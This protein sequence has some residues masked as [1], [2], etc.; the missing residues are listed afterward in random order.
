VPLR[1]TICCIAPDTIPDFNP[2]KI[3][4]GSFYPKEA[5][6]T[7]EPVMLLVFF[8]PFAPLRETICCIAPDTISYFYSPKIRAGA[9]NPKGLLSIG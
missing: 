8:A 1:E 5:I 6:H 7:S 2:P 9:F 4:A 3:R